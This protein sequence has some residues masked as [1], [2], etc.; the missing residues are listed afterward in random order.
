VAK[1]WKRD[2]FKNAVQCDQRILTTQKIPMKTI[3]VLS[4]SWSNGNT[5]K[6]LA[7]TK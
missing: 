1:F 2:N 5:R 3:L 4:H 7:G 6:E